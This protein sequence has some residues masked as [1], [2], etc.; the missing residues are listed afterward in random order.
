MT[1]R[2]LLYLE[3][4]VILILQPV[5]QGRIG[6]AQATNNEERNETKLKSR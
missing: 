3:L 2:L 6:Q 5:H 1:S 4:I